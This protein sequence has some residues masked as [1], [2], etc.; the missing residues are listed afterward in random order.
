MR[1]PA[2]VL[3]LLAATSCVRGHL[4]SCPNGE[5][6][7]VDTVCDVAHG[8]CVAP[9]QLDVCTTL[10]DR[11]PCEAGS[12]IGFCFDEVCV[13]PGCGNQA[14]EDGE[15][16]DDGN[17]ESGDDRDCWTTCTPACPPYAT[18]P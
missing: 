13:A 8:G 5:V 6:C 9:E 3:V 4:V 2:L 11:E 12:I 16:C 10:G 18:C 7:P 1:S 14:V 17:R 15:L